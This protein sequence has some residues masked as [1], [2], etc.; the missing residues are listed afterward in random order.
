M[1]QT[2]EHGI[3]EYFISFDKNL[4]DTE[5]RKLLNGNNHSLIPM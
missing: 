5:I 4:L 1:Y 2:G 3:M